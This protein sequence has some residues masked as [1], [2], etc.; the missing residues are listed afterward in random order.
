MQ[1][2]AQMGRNGRAVGRDMGDTMYAMC[3]VCEIFVKAAVSEPGWRRG[4]A[5]GHAPRGYTVPLGGE[6][7]GNRSVARFLQLP[8][9]PR[10]M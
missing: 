5:C 2:V 3:A 6:N 1:R 9:R 10:R 8:W 4:S 7:G